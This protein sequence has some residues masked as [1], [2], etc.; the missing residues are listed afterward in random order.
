MRDVLSILTLSVIVPSANEGQ[1]LAPLPDKEG[2]AG[3]F[4]GASNGTLKE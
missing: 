1:S 4:V 2:L 3:S